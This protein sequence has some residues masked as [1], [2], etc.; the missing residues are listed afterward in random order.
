MIKETES[1]RLTCQKKKTSKY[2]RSSNCDRRKKGKA[3]KK[4]RR[5]EIEPWGRRS[6]LGEKEDGENRVGR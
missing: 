3:K 2:Q 1:V 6:D 5:G 4:E